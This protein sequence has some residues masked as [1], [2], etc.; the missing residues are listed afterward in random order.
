MNTV[1]LLDLPANRTDS[2]RDRICVPHA[3]TTALARIEPSLHVVPERP[4]RRLNMALFRQKRDTVFLAGEPSPVLPVAGKTIGGC[5]TTRDR[6][7]GLR[8]PACFAERS[9]DC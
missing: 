4:N 1:H 9:V 2:G 7:V 8:L 5:T 3:P 6:L